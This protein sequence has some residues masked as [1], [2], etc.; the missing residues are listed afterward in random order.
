VPAALLKFEGCGRYQR[1][2]HPSYVVG[3]AMLIPCAS[4]EEVAESIAFIWE[5]PQCTHMT[6]RPRDDEPEFLRERAAT[7]RE[8][9]ATMPH[10]V[11]AKLREVACALKKRAAR[12]ALN[13]PTPG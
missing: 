12:L 8:R 3:Q 5:K 1:T 11:A 2:E 4:E 10:S 7:L 13:E 6:D 9:A